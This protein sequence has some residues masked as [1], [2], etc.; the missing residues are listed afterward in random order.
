MLGR[1][2]MFHISELFVLATPE[3][4][5][6]TPRK[7][8]GLRDF[9]DDGSVDVGEIESVGT[10][11]A[12]GSVMEYVRESA[13]RLA[14]GRLLPFAELFRPAAWLAARA[15]GPRPIFATITEDLPHASNR[16]SEEAGRIVVSYTTNS[17][18][19]QHS[20]R[21]RDRVRAAFAPLPVR[22][23]A[24]AGRPN[25]GHPMGTCRMGTDPETSV[26]T[27]QGQLRGHEQILS[28]MRRRFRPPAA[29]APR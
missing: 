15:I 3:A 23:L 29:P 14:G 18:L 8:L 5:G 12:T 28:P 22:F 26:T 20:R 19:K 7:W 25:W 10:D 17:R 4:A 1:G 27:P 16:V 21:M 9:Y 2:L 13:A 11:V 6:A 24:S